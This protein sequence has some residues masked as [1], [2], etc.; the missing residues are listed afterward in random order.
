ML[1][2]YDV[3]TYNKQLFGGKMQSG[4]FK[5]NDKKLPHTVIFLI[6][7]Q[8]DDV[9]LWEFYLAEV[10]VYKNQMRILYVSDCKTIRIRK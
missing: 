1:L 5:S 4:L 8:S 9:N 3:F 7:F 2:L 6:I 10:M